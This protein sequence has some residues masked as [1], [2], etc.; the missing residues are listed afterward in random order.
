[1][2][3]NTVSLEPRSA[4]RMSSEVRE[5]RHSTSNAYKSYLNNQIKPRWD[6]YPLSKV[7]PFAVKQWL[8]G[9]DLAPRTKGHLHNLMRVLWN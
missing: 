1:M 7:K 6:D 9:L 5:L 2:N 3:K 8:K 4:S